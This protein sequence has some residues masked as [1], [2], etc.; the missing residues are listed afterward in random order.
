MRRM[1]FAGSKKVNL[2]RIFLILL[3]LAYVLTINV[4]F[5]SVVSCA[6]LQLKVHINPTLYGV[7]FIR[8]N[9]DRQLFG[10]K[11]QSASF[12]V[13][14]TQDID[15]VDPVHLLQEDE[16]QDG[17]GTQSEVVRGESL[18]QGKEP[19]VSRHLGDDV[20]GSGVLGLPVN[21]FHILD[22]MQKNPRGL[23]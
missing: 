17:V 19:F 16:S 20:N 4:V 2:S 14:L 13:L 18:P 10:Q 21:H 8:E 1:N 11:L 3:P 15:F 23:A 12:G 6:V 5:P 22:P 7:R 9:V